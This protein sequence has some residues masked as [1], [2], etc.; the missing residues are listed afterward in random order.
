MDQKTEES[1]REATGI[2]YEWDLQ[3]KQ[4]IVKSFI[5]YFFAMLSKII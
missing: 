5:I 4:H 3:T 2:K 1:G